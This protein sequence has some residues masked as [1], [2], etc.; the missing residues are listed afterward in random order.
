MNKK[1]IL[2]NIILLTLLVLLIFKENYIPKIYNIIKSKSSSEINIET[3]DYKHETALYKEYNKKGNIVM[4]GN[5]ITYRVHWNELL[6]RNDIINRGIGHDITKGMLTRLNYVFNANPR[7][8]F[9]MG[10]INDINKGIDTEV[11][12]SNLNQISDKLKKKNIK[13][14]IYS[15][16]YVAESYPEYEQKN[17][18]ILN[19]NK[20]IETMCLKNDIEFINLNHT[21]SSN[22]ALKKM[23]SFDGLHLT[24]L[25]YV[26]WKEIIAPI[27]NREIEE[28]NKT[29][30]Q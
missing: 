29:K 12:V 30:H 13:P 17:K 6:N 16:I 26:K 11:I 23:Y 9:I 3:E 19:T 24:A 10:G 14:I 18:L 4:L 20:E 15:I 5:S 25:G 27:I 22:K 7:I 21:L 1:N 2:V 28:Q 8:C